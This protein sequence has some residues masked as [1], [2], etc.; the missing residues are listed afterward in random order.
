[1][2]NFENYTK[3]GNVGLGYSIAYYTSKGYIVA[4]P[5]NDAQ[6]YDLIYDNG[7][8]NRV[9]VKTTRGK[10]KSGKFI[11]QLKT[12]SGRKNLGFHPDKFD[13]LFVLTEDFKMYEIPSIK[14]M[15]YKSAIVLNENFEEYKLNF[16]L[17]N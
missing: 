10:S 14:L 9:Q 7:K 17:L 4:L 2:L 16:K 3:Q 13:F 11:V 6:K 8:L 15:N 1:M 5:L 12:V